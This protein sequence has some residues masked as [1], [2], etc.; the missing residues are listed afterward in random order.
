METLVCYRNDCGNYRTSSKTT[1]GGS[2]IHNNCQAL[3]DNVILEPECCS[4]F[5]DKE[6]DWLICKRGNKNT[7]LYMEITEVLQE[8]YG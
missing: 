7:K 3:K 5:I 8:K 4:C 2:S 6:K 1:Q